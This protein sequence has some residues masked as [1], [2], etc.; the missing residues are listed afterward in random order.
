MKERK[1]NVREKDEKQ[2][3]KQRGKR[4]GDIIT[5]R[6]KSDYRIPQGRKSDKK[7][8]EEEKL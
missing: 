1:E 7:H 6:L 4:Q 5:K 8:F 3:D 2:R